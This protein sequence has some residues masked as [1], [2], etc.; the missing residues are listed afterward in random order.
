MNTR[1]L[2]RLVLGVVAV[3]LGLVPFAIPPAAH[4][5]QVTVTV[6]IAGA[7][8]VQVV[9]GTLEDGGSYS[10]DR[11]ANLDHRVVRTCPAI[12]NE[13]PFEAW[14]WLRPVMTG[15][16]AGW[17]FV[18]WQ[19]C[20]ETRTNTIGTRDCAVHSGAF[21]SVEKYPVAVYRDVEAPVIT[22]FG[23]SQVENEQ[24][25]FQVTWSATGHVRNECQLDGAAWQACTSPWVLSLSSGGHDVAVRAVD[26]SG[27]LSQTRTARMYS[28]DTRI[29][30]MPPKVA[31][32]RSADFVFTSEHSTAFDCTLD[33]KPTACADG[34]LQLKALSEGTHLL[35]VAGRNGTWVDP[36]PARW[37]WTVDTIAPDT[38]VLGGP[39]EGSTTTATSAEFTLVA[40]GAVFFA[41]TIDHDPIPCQE[42]PVR[43]SG[44]TPGR[45]V[46]E[47]SASDAAGNWY[48][49]A[50]K[51]TW[52]VQAPDRSA[53]D[54]TLGGGPADGSIATAPDATFELG[55]TEPGARTSCTLDGVALPCAPGALGLTGLAPG[56]H[57][58]SVTSTDA[59]GNTDAS[60]ATRTWTVPAPA[61]ALKGKG[62]KLRSVAG[63]YAGKALT[64]KRKGATASYA[65]ADARRLALVVSK[66]KK[67]GKVKVYAGKRLL[68]TV[69]LKGA[70]GTR[71]VVLV[72]TFAAPFTGKV[73]IVAATG[74][75]TVQ[76]EGIAAPTR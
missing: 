63:S 28:L 42:G 57:V 34:R 72:S 50:A 3:A 13:E 74:G 39:A 71:Q 44:L 73:R 41:C 37:E 16:P 6:G 22:A 23:A 35:T 55:T 21:N 15:V 58:L 11:T 18:Q 45:H 60:P 32:S 65:V 20:D 66:G 51:R 24:N 38:T 49:P 40:P 5:G 76:I 75:K 64:T 68:R 48:S 59:N 29:T 14:V 9:E 27:N 31:N 33:G 70:A 47:A 25:F 62:W 26:A 46:F 10:C 7:G 17:E 36:V 61:S 2:V 53:P 12:R 69:S 30:G 56:T 52:T 1:Q 43:L 8:R 67:L 4:A 19:G 54:T